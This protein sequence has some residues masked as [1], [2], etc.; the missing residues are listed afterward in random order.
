MVSGVTGEVEQ[1]SIEDVMLAQAATSTE[2]PEYKDQGLIG[3][4]GGVV[5]I[6]NDQGEEIA[7]VTLQPGFLK[8]QVLV[9]LEEVP[10][11]A[12]PGRYDYLKFYEDDVVTQIGPQVAVSFP[13]SAINLESA[14]ELVVFVEPHDGT[15]DEDAQNIYETQ[16]TMGNGQVRFSEMAL[17]VYVAPDNAR[18]IVVSSL[19]GA[20]S[21]PPFSNDPPETYQ[22][23]V[24]PLSFKSPQN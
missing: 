5:Y 14:A 17:D 1:V 8:E 11:E 24:Q 7:F 2:F 4:E 23:V 21:F 12:P 16:F 13:Y 20:Y 6:E 10:Y 15:Y 9:T 22:L 3:A 19:A 18:K